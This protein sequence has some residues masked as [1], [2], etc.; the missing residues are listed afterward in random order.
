MPHIHESIDISG[1]QGFIL[2]MSDGL[3]KAYE[4][5][6]KRP[7]RI[8]E[9]L[10]HLVA[11][12]FKNCQHGEDERLVAQNVVEKVKHLYK[13]THKRAMTPGRLDDITLIVKRLGLAHSQSM[14][15]SP[16]SSTH[17]YGGDVLQT[18]PPGNDKPFDFSNGRQGYASVPKNMASYPDI[19]GSQQQPPLATFQHQPSLP[20]SSTYQSAVP[21][22]HMSHTTRFEGGG[23][24]AAV[25]MTHTA[26]DLPYSRQQLQPGVSGDY[27]YTSPQHGARQPQDNTDYY[28]STNTKTSQYDSHYYRQQRQQDS[29][30]MGNNAPLPPQDHSRMA[31]YPEASR[32]AIPQQSL[33]SGA[34]GNQVKGLPFQPHGGHP[35]SNIEVHGAGSGGSVSYNQQQDP[36]NRM[37]FQREGGGQSVPPVQE[38]YSSHGQGEMLQQQRPVH[39]TIPGLSSYMSNYGPSSGQGPHHQDSSYGQPHQ[40]Y[41]QT[42]AED[43]PDLA[44]PIATPRSYFA[45]RQQSSSSFTSD[46]SNSSSDLTLIRNTSMAAVEEAD[47]LKEDDLFTQSRPPQGA[48][49]RAGE[50]PHFKNIEEDS[51]QDSE[52]PD[53]GY[54]SE[55]EEE[56][57]VDNEEAQSASGSIG[58]DIR[59][60][61][62]FGDDFPAELSWFEIPHTTNQ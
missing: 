29:L 52:N 58:D 56:E 13:E 42:S 26:G 31:H 32:H 51:T 41:R 8:N 34:G 27:S 5:W 55:E 11:R 14:V 24:G 18:A 54:L 43:N 37:S 48:A 2:F 53:V 22:H 33:P 44:T 4:E 12:E 62:K 10:A 38:G 21:E 19:M 7:D 30:A 1:S 60:Y 45:N 9:D 57:E 17:P 16:A 46:A 3:Y 25:G 47:T 61:V 59:P 28:D 23:A 20:P 15:I 50:N 36:G 35:Q 6:S 40:G 39:P 49:A